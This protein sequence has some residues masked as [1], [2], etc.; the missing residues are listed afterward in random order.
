MDNYEQKIYGGVLGKTI[1]VYIGR[2]FEGWYKA[3]IEARFG[4]ID[5]YVNEELGVQL[6]VTDDDLTGTFTFLRILKDSGDYAGTAPDR[7][8]AN[9]LNY[10]IPDKSI[11][12]WGGVGISTEH[13]AFK[14]LKNGIQAPHSGTIAQNGKIVAEQIGAQ[15]FIEGFGMVAPGNPE[16]AA[17]LARQAAQ[18]SHDGA[19]V[20]AAII[21]AAMTSLAFVQNDIAVIMRE[22]LKHV[23]PSS[24]IYRVHQQVRDWVAADNDWQRTYS[25]IKDQYGYDKFGGLCH[26]IPNH[27][28]MVM[29]WL[30][31]GADFDLAMEIINTA[32]WDTD[33]NAANVGCVLGIMLGPAKIN[34]KTD[35]RAGFNDRLLLPT[36]E[37]SY[38]VTDCANV[39]RQ[40]ATIGRKIMEWPTANNQTPPALH[41]F[42]LPGSLHGYMLEG[43][44][45]HKIAVGI[46]PDTNDH[47]EVT[48][49]NPDGSGMNI[50]GQIRQ[51]QELRLSTPLLAADQ[52]GNYGFIGCSR[53]QGGNVVRARLCVSSLSATINAK[54]FL[55]C[56]NDET[57]A[58]DTLLYSAP[59]ILDTTLDCQ[60]EL[61]VPPAA[62]PVYDV[63]L[64]I[65]CSAAADFALVMTELQVSGNAEI[66]VVGALPVNRD[67]N[68][69]G[70][71]V[72]GSNCVNP[73][74]HT[75]RKIQTFVNNDDR[76][77][78]CVG[79]RDWQNYVFT[80]E[81]VKFCAQR[82]GIVVRYQG[83]ERYLA[84]TISGDKLQIIRRC[85]GEEL[86][87]ESDYPV[88]YA[89]KIN[90]KIV[91]GGEWIE[92]Y[93]ADELLYRW[94]EP[95][96]LD[97]GV[98][99]LAEQ[100]TCGFERMTLKCF[101]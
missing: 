100:G 98:G 94:R 47:D 60:L 90:F 22:A 48:I 82:S 86:L 55:R 85:Y 31:A 40:I 57:K 68:L 1:G 32:G 51:G 54:L 28:L 21:V 91:A 8:G 76:G 79:T 73:L 16:L 9:W 61:I 17:R 18:V 39:S 96:L 59:A 13:T 38:S 20:D 30:Y 42:I 45:T 63:G 72:Y 67:N 58:L 49:T 2:P 88:S 37:G 5:R 46:K 56:F 41:N 6:V 70:W 53:I 26:V 74:L 78:F 62:G 80:T 77:L 50:S 12:W 3:A 11:L 43:S 101:S 4:K 83:L 87:F 19:A 84:L 66:D 69:P 23:Q 64:E 93:L 95:V 81:F 75:A 71:I 65:S 44:R 27:A 89:D 25:R 29:S 35:W 97:G 24:A 15:I 92:F 10:I 99:Y 33:C 14:N 52:S 36:A 34:E 7:Y